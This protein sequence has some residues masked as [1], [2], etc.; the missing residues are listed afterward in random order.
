MVISCGWYTCHVNMY[1]ILYLKF[2][3]GALRD[4]VK[5]TGTEVQGIVTVTANEGPLQMHRWKLPWT[6]IW[7][8]GFRQK[9]QD[10]IPKGGHSNSRYSCTKKKKP[11]S[12]PAN[13]KKHTSG[14]SATGTDLSITNDSTNFAKEVILT[15]ISINCLNNCL[16]I[17]I[18][19]W[20]YSGNKRH[21]LSTHKILNCH[22][23]W[24][25]TKH[26]NTH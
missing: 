12:L 18:C 14:L 11:V 1:C 23:F 6:K 10:N 15:L 9:C 21:D 4:N 25:T 24:K 7:T 26:S 13:A 3:L 5:A 8:C 16:W 2:T 22:M 20:Q 17:P 19:I